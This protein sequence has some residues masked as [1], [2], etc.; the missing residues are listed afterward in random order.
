MPFL[1]R[2]TQFKPFISFVTSLVTRQYENN[3]ASY[4]FLV[5]SSSDKIVSILLLCSYLRLPVDLSLLFFLILQLI[6][7]PHER[8][9]ISLFKL[10]V[11]WAWEH[12]HSINPNFS[13]LKFVY[14]IIGIV[15]F[16][17][18]PVF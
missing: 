5:V 8:S 3:D 9:I 11:D 4:F 15:F 18:K 13:M 17:F 10:L 14:E 6:L 16:S 1:Y 2:S 12:S 7:F